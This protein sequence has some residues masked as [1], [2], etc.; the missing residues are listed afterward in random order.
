LQQ[1]NLNALVD[2]IRVFVQPIFINGRRYRS[3]S[4][5]INKEKETTIKK[6]AA[7][8]LSIPLVA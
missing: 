8:E 3:S 4:K 1:D 2:H 7:A 5:K 6:D